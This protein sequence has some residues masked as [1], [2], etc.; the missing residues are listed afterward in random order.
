LCDDIDNNALDPLPDNSTNATDINKS[1]ATNATTKALQAS[2][3]PPPVTL[4]WQCAKAGMEV[5]CP[6][7]ATNNYT[8]VIVGLCGSGEH[9]ACKID[10]KK[11]HFGCDH[12]KG[13]DMMN[14]AIACETGF[15]VT[16]DED[17]CYHECMD[18][19]EW[20][21][22]AS[23]FV[24]VAHCAGAGNPKCGHTVAE[25]A[26]YPRTFSSMKCCQIRK[27]EWA[28]PEGRWNLVASVA[29]G[30][31][32]SETLSEGISTTDTKSVTH[33]WSKSVT[34]SISSGFSF[35][36]FSF[37]ISVSKTVSRSVSNTVTHSTTHTLTNTCKATCSPHPDGL[38]VYLYQWHMDFKRGYGTSYMAP[39]ST[40]DT[41]N[42]YC[43]YSQQPQSPA[44]PLGAC[45]D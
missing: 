16:I 17:S 39:T 9:G 34:R 30:G 38:P 24:A 31:Q 18:A 41:C 37:S 12:K 32:I 26:S 1:D 21:T 11:G 22:C 14:H 7:N 29:G 8:G 4:E 44:C 20:K 40:L 27:P 3:T 42:Y 28:P 35:F 19:E 13:H 5:Q 15:D 23:G 25:C 45:Y 33:S 36:G 6:I 2:G 43:V 10:S